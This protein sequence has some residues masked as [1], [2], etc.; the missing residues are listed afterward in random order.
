[1]VKFEKADDHNHYHLKNAA[2]YTL[3]NQDKTAQVAIAQKT[4]AGFCLEDSAFAGGAGPATYTT[5][6]AGNSFCWQNDKNHGGTLVMGISP[7]WKDVY[8]AYLTYQWIDISNVQP[9]QYNLAARVDPLNVI[10]ESDEN[11]GY[12][13]L[14][15]IVAGYVAKPVATPQT[16]GQ[17]TITLDA[18]QFG[19]TG[20]RKFRIL[21]S[22]QHGTL[23]K[24]PGDGPFSASTVTYTPTPG[25]SGADSFTYGAIND[26]S[27]GA[28]AIVG[29]PTDYVS[30]TRPNGYPL[31]PAAAT[32]NI[33]TAAPSVAI[34]GSPA[35]MVAGTSVQLTSTLANLTGGVTWSTTGGT[36]TPTGLLTAPATAGTVTVTAT[37]TAN[38]AVTATVTIDVSGVPAPRPAYGVVAA[39]T[40]KPKKVALLGAVKTGHIGRR[41]IVGKVITG[42]KHGRVTFTATIKRKVIGRCSARVPARRTFLCKIVMKRN[43]PLTK[44][45]MTAKLKFGKK[46][47]VKRAYVV[48]RAA[49]RR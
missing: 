25:Y 24:T 4:E 39:V 29:G 27:D 19:V 48:K 7:G 1:M 23:S 11:N 34:S 38:P 2:E 37:S 6:Q 33:T 5:G 3:W 10:R 46:S 8:G 30:P 31:N 43:Y 41:T 22:P 36:I 14:P 32:V 13:Y 28:G 17:K 16:G 18:A 20:A 47:V 44:V 12:K 35:G 40:P 26:G 49:R 15:Y 21:S 45:L 42:R 9:G